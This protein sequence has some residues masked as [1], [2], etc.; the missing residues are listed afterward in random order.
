MLSIQPS[1]TFAVAARA[2]SLKAQGMDITS[3]SMGEP[4]FDTPEYI[5]EAAISAIRAGQTKYTAVEGTLPL[6]KAIVDKFEQDNHLIYEP[7]QILVSSGAKQSIFNALQALIDEQDEVI[8]SA[9]YWVSYPEIVSVC[10]GQPVIIE[11][12]QGE[13]F[14][15]TPERLEQAIT[16]KTK[17]LILNSPANPTGVV[18]TSKEL[19]ALAEVLLRHPQVYILSDDIYEHLYWSSEKFHNLLMVCDKLYDRTLLVNGVSKTYAMTGWRIGYAAGPLELI[20]A[21]GV[22]QSQS[23]SNACSISQ[24]AAFAALKGEAINL[25]PMVQTFK[26]R[27]DYLFSALNRI[28][29]FLCQAAEGAFYLFV[30]IKKAMKSLPAVQ[31]DVAF[32]DYLLSYAHV[33]VVPGSAFGLEGY[34]RFS[35]A[36]DINVLEKAVERIKNLFS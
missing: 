18:Y 12:L 24:A 35:Y 4:D 31:D 22:L 29:G 36:V 2:A 6:R 5:K 16:P 21:M 7:K 26:Q 14:K 9:P 28:P 23:T 32:T 8:L 17:L 25:M 30:D 20:Q 15:I 3:L 34:V 11:T 1:P 10:G 13:G 19:K 27:H 33:S